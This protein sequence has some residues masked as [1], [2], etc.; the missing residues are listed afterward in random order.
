MRNTIEEEELD[1]VRIGSLDLRSSTDARCF[2]GHDKHNPTSCHDGEESDDV[3]DANNIQD[4][5]SLSSSFFFAE[6]EHIELVL[7]NWWSWK[8]CMV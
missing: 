4:D 7:K 2:D 3:E 6:V 1:D 5:V 8:E